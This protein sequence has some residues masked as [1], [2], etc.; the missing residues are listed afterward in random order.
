M[1]APFDTTRSYRKDLDVRDWTLWKDRLLEE[2]PNGP[3]WVILGPRRFG[4][5]W[6][7]RGIEALLSKFARYVDLGAEPDALNETSQSI[8][9]LDEPG[10]AL[11]ADARAF[12]ERC[13]SLSERTK[14]VLAVTPR[15]W[16]QLVAA[17]PE[18]ARNLRLDRQLLPPL[19]PDQ[20]LTLARTKKSQDILRNLPTSWTL[21]SFLLELTF[22]VAESRGLEDVRAVVEATQRHCESGNIQY[23]SQVFEDGLNLVQQ[24]TLRA[25][26]GWPHKSADPDAINLLSDCGLLAA[27]GA[28][29]DPVLAAHLPPPLIIHHVSDMHIGDATRDLTAGAIDAKATGRHGARLAAGAGP[30]TVRDSYATYVEALGDK[31]DAP[32]VLIVSGDL[33]E[34][35]TD[36]QLD[37]AKAWIGRVEAA[38]TDHPDL[39]K[40]EQRVLLAP[41]NHDVHWDVAAD[42]DRARHRRF[43][44]TFKD[45]PRP[46]LEEAPDKRA[47]AHVRFEKMGVHVVLLGSAENGGELVDDETHR[48]LV[49]L[50]DKARGKAKDALDKDD[51][52]T[53]DRLATAVN[54]IDPGLVHTADLNRIAK[55][56]WVLPVRIAV[57]HHPLSPLPVAPEVAPYAGV[58]NAGAVKDTLL[59]AG[60]Q[61]VLHGHQHSGWF[62]KETW[63]GR[64]GERTL[65]IAAAPTLGSRQTQENLGFNEIR[66]FR[67]GARK[68]EVSVR[69]FGREGTA[70]VQM[71]AEMVFSP[72]A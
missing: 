5:T 13:R 40:D 63:P 3:F 20:A 33:V 7:L 6:A 48:D 15:E 34:T 64:H 68:F 58:I 24:D 41:G 59:K 1:T 45:R 17:V 71:G 67:E 2:Q 65:H 46:R 53:Y 61:L 9:L 60:F 72:P 11:K 37:T 66:V 4:K 49:A 56:N 52:A 36:T 69:R 18:L 16:A 51:W 29:G 27:G 19:T 8:L 30:A 25:V 32:H 26:A 70:W 14:I 35:S 43:A 47:L 31:T 10:R 12:V 54:R 57:L 38:L 21:S 28:I 22:Q 55:E 50:L 23:V 42:G 44:E 62:A 39:A